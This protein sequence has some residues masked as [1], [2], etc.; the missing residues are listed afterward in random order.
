MVRGGGAMGEG[1]YWG[2][3]V[4]SG[5]MADDEY[6]EADEEEDAMEGVGVGD[7]IMASSGAVGIYGVV[8]VEEGTL[9]VCQK[10]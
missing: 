6:K 7:R 9:Y 1:E 3:T 2:H 10:R 8:C 5:N 4:V